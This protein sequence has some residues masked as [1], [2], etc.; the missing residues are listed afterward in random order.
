MDELEPERKAVE[1]NYRTLESETIIL[2]ST[3]YAVLSLILVWGVF[4][5]LLC[6]P[7][8]LFAIIVY[9]VVSIFFL[10][11]I[12]FQS[13]RRTKLNKLP[14][15]NILELCYLVKEKSNYDDDEAGIPGF[16][17]CWNITCE[18]FNNHSMNKLFSSNISQII[19]AHDYFSYM[20]SEKYINVSAVT[21]IGNDISKNHLS[22]SL[23]E[24][25]V[26]K[27]KIYEESVKW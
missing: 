12:G 26:S 7:Y 10:L 27:L 3:I 20:I 24:K 18:S 25:A 6:K 19:P 16:R 17:G 2:F 11:F 23:S 4:K 21:D 9:T 8:E 13:R 22:I 15:E 5:F 1:R 14:S